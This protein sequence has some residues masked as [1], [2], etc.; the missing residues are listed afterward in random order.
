MIDRNLQHQNPIILKFRFEVSLIHF[1]CSVTS[2][3]FTYI[4]KKL[5]TLTK[6]KSIWRLNWCDCDPMRWHPGLN[7]GENENTRLKMNEG[8]LHVRHR[9]GVVKGRKNWT[10]KR[11]NRVYMK[12]PRE[13]EKV[14]NNEPVKVRNNTRLNENDELVPNR[15][16]RRGWT[17]TTSSCTNKSR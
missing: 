9:R 2:S 6:E 5:G 8:K 7:E 13:S 16:S 10:M 15:R 3:L 4:S 12:M 11:I 17:K 14:V 1:K